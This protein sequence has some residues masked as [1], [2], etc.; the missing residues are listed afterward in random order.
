MLSL[1]IWQEA[2]MNAVEQIMRD[3]EKME[4]YI[5]SAEAAF[6]RATMADV[7]VRKMPGLQAFIDSA[8]KM[9]RQYAPEL[10][11]LNASQLAFE[12]SHARGMAR[13]VISPFPPRP[14]KRS[15]LPKR[16]IV[17][18]EVKRRIGFLSD[19]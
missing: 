15:A 7:Y 9:T 17:R 12:Q 11:A 16:T 19:K 3:H 2:G 18:H 5:R 8:E 4:A 14:S 10:A 6:A 13:P 1:D